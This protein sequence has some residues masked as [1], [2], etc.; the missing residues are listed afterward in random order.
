[1][2][3]EFLSRG[4]PEEAAELARWVQAGQIEFGAF[5]AQPLTQVASLEELLRSTVRAR[6]LA[7]QFGAE[8]VTALLTD[9]AGATWNLPQVLARAGVR[10]FLL[11]TGAFRVHVNQA[12]LP[13][14]FYFTAPDGSRV[15]LYQIG[16]D[17]EEDPHTVT[18]LNATY[19]FGGT[20]LI[21]PFREFL[22]AGSTAGFNAEAEEKGVAEGTGREALDG[23]LARLEREGYPYDALLLQAAGDNRGA[24]PDL[25]ETVRLWNEWIRMPEVRIATPREFF[26][27]VEARYGADLPVLSGDLTCPWS[28]M[29]G[30]MAVETGRYR[31]ASRRWI[32]GETLGS[33][34]TARTG[35][36]PAPAPSRAVVR[37]LL[38]YS[39]HT[40]GQSMWNSYQVCEA[41]GT[42]HDSIFDSARATWQDKRDYVDAADRQTRRTLHRALTGWANAIPT[43]R[44]EQFV[45]INP[46]SWERA[47]VVDYFRRSEG[48]RPTAVRDVATGELLPVDVMDAGG[49]RV[50]ITFR[51]PPVPGLGYR[52]LESEGDKGVS[53]YRISP[54][55]QIDGRTME[56]EFLRIE[57]DERTGSL[58]QLVD[59]HTGRDFVDGDAPWTL[60]QMLYAGLEG[61]S[62]DARGTGLCDDIRRTWARV[63]SVEFLPGTAGR[64]RG[65]LRVRARLEGGPA[66]LTV[67]S[68]IRLA[69]GQPTVEFFNT[70]VKPPTADIE[71]GFL[72]FPFSLRQPTFYVAQAGCAVRVPED[73]LPGSAQHCLGI[74]DWV[75]LEDEETV[76]LWTTDE[77][78]VIEL[79]EVR[80]IG[81]SNLPQ[82][83]ARPHLLAYLFNNT[84]QTNCQRWQG[85]A[86]PFRVTL[87]VLPPPYDPVAVARQ[88]QAA[89]RPLLAHDGVSAAEAGVEPV[90]CWLGVEPENVL[91]STFKP[92][93]GG[94]G[95]VL[96]CVE[97]AGQSTE[98]CLDVS[99]L[100][101][102]EWARMDLREQVEGDWQPVREDGIRFR[103]SPHEI[104]T[105][106]LRGQD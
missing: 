74:Q 75:A 52:I 6:E 60:N 42:L 81:I 21:R 105:V 19:G 31:Q 3:D 94:E 67:E 80:S 61:L 103:L 84:W 83:P 54:A 12:S 39:D 72:A 93:E 37:E 22:A 47:D 57:L 4:G 10:Y 78:A 30:S 101:L 40:F 7:A 85:G 102:S 27:D 41:V 76:L 43:A 48:P 11:G 99:A 26:A 33:L 96:R 95:W 98:A 8:V 25:P 62:P 79:G 34:L 14:L 13:R 53:P 65:T 90:G 56:N 70:V 1:V 66:P 24:D 29:L 73:Q 97:V 45:V 46:C 64:V 71:E 15:L 68:E 100:S 77:A 89:N 92:A 44:E 49:P 23:L 59:K 5:E 17:R 82:R 87:T 106:G 88:G 91:L 104:A 36:P 51:P 18:Q 38:H 86:W 35:Q 69:A 55:V 28:D 16:F 2:V 9:I 58:A 20:Y 63:E 50:R 32:V